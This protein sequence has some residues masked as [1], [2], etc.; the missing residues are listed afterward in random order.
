MIVDHALH[1][2]LNQLERYMAG[3]GAQAA[4]I[5]HGAHI[6]RA[7]AVETGKLHAIVTKLLDL[8][9]S[10]VHIGFHGVADGI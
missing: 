3:Y 7:M 4:F 1:I 5:Q 2:R 8:R 10:R 6:L 9:E